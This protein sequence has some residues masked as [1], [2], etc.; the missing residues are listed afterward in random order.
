MLKKDHN[1]K[2]YTNKERMIFLNVLLKL[3]EKHNQ[4]W[5]LEIYLEVV[6]NTLWRDNTIIP[7][8]VNYFSH[9]HLKS[10]IEAKDIQNQGIRQ[11]RNK[12]IV[13]VM[14]QITTL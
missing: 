2:L 3:W 13:D 5:I 6:R 1:A 9:H 10:I 12:L 7:N 14:I 11:E 4:E 8:M